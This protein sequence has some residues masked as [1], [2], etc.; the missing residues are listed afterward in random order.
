MASAWSPEVYQRAALLAA[1][2]HQGQTLPNL[3]APYLVHLMLVAAEVMAAL[4]AED[5]LD[6]DLAVACAL[7]HDTL[8]GTAVGY[9]DLRQEFGARVADGVQALTKDPA[10]SKGEQMADSLRR[11]QEQP[12]EIALVKLADQTVNLRP[13]PAGWPVTG[14]PRRAWSET[15]SVR[16]SPASR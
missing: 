1:G 10:L 5:G 8:E 4:Q 15:V 9:A 16:P 11:I 6:G 7:P 12:R 13:A 2:A 3:P 14:R